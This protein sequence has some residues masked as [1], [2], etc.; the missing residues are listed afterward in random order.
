MN[1]MLG[2]VGVNAPGA[3]I[4]AGMVVATRASFDQGDRP[5]QKH[6]KSSLTSAQSKGV[7]HAR[8]RTLRLIQT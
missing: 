3:T 6:P 1:W 2:I 7:D 5:W 4:L 8:S